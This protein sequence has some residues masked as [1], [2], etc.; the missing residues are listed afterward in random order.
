MFKLPTKLPPRPAVMHRPWFPV[1][2]DNAP[3]ANANAYLFHLSMMHKA[4]R[5]AR[6]EK[7]RLIDPQNVHQTIGYRHLID[8]TNLTLRPVP[9]WRSYVDFGVV[10]PPDQSVCRLFFRTLPISTRCT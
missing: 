6:F 9:P 4:D 7:F 2:L 8:E 10:R 5:Q 1:E 3:K